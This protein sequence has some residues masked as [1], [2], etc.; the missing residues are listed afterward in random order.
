MRRIAL[1]QLLI[2]PVPP[3]LIRQNVGVVIEYD[4]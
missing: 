4:D 1:S 3:V 2:I